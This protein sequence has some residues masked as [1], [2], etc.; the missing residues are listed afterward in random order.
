MFRRF[1]LKGIKYRAPARTNAT[2]VPYYRPAVTKSD[3]KNSDGVFK[4]SHRGDDDDGGAITTVEMERARFLADLKGHEFF[5][6]ERTK[7]AVK[8]ANF[9]L[10][11][12]L[13]RVREY[14]YQR[15]R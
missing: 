8:F 5:S 3:S 9:I 4:Y 12:S 15:E 2:R 14:V 10:S 11:C 1:L 7:R 6:T 13:K